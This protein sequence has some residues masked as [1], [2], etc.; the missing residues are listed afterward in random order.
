MQIFFATYD[1]DNVRNLVRRVGLLR[2]L[3]GVQMLLAGKVRS[4][5]DSWAPKRQ[6]ASAGAA[7]VPSYGDVIVFKSDTA[8]EEALASPTGK[9]LETDAQ[10]Q[11]KNLTTYSG[12]GQAVV[13]F[14]NRR[15][16]DRCFVAIG[17]FV[18]DPAYGSRAEAEFHYVAA[19]TRI[20]GRFPGCEGYLMTIVENH[21]EE[22]AAPQRLA[23][24]IYKDEPALKSALKS[25]A[26]RDLE[27]DAR[28]L[29]KIAALFFLDAQI[30]I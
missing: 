18:F 10:A 28:G 7:A 25:Q 16:G 12:H 3:P 4:G 17:G 1:V 19:H 27:Q 24:S 8:A 20:A 29:S 5:L 2:A 23:F 22:P 13:S 21:P 30:E 9:L 6:L 14:E 15:R 26:A 11:V